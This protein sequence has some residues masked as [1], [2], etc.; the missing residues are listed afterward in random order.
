MESMYGLTVANF[1]KI[2]YNSKLTS[3][4][5]LLVYKMNPFSY[6]YIFIYCPLTKTHK[7]ML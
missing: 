1:E 6:M 2:F 4:E 7:S 5:I 3:Y